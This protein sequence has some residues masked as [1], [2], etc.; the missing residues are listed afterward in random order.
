MGGQQIRAAIP[1]G[2]ACP[3]RH[4]H[5][6]LRLQHTQTASDCEKEGLDKGRVPRICA[7][8]RALV[9][10]VAMEDE[11][12]KRACK[13]LASGAAQRTAI[14]ASASLSPLA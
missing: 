6:R 4:A 5:P 9:L 3:V 12:A 8:G 13:V 7:A 10:S 11:E 1:L 2:P 14:D